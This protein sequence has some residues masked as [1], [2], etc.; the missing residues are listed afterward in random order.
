MMRK[1]FFAV[2][3]VAALTFASCGNK[4][5]A[6][7]EAVDSTTVDTT[8]LAPETMTTFKALSAQLISALD[9]GSADAVTQALANFEAMYK[10]LANTGNLEDLKGY[11]VLVK[12]LIAENADKIKSV[13]NGNATI[14]SL[15]SSIE[16]LPTSAGVTLEDAKSAV[17]EQAVGLANESLQKG[18]SAEATAEA[19]TEALKNASAAA[20]ESME[21]AA[22]NAKSAAKAA[23]DQVASDA[24]KTAN[25]AKEGINN[26]VKDVEKSV[27]KTTKEA[28]QKTGEAID[29]A[30]NAV[31]GKL[32]L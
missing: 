19:A 23:A 14:A 29:K 1:L 11:G 17:S 5:N 7:A 15:V 31:K 9:E 24:E 13:A 2:V 18:A 16:A 27:N 25:E 32:G 3:A 28:K 10:T 30:S 21:D 20:K 22:A 12:N 26:A 8:A 6:N 4:S